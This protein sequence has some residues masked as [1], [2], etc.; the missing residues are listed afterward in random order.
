MNR[1][2]LESHSEISGIQNESNIDNMIPY[3]SHPNQDFTRGH[4]HLCMNSFVL[5]YNQ[6]CR[7]HLHDRQMKRDVRDSLESSRDECSTLDG[8]ALDDFM[9]NSCYD[10]DYD[11]DFSI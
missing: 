1:S 5:E 8:S 3:I 6:E 7:N 2:K 11:D 4:Q 10:S 9:D